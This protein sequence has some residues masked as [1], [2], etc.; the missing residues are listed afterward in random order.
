MTQKLLSILLVVLTLVG[1]VVAQAPTPP[2][3]F[4]VPVA[5]TGVNPSGGWN[6][7]SI[8]SVGALV[9]SG[10]TGNTD[11]NPPQGF[12]VPFAPVGVDP[13][14]NWAFMKVDNT[15]AIII[16]GALP[17]PYGANGTCLVSTGP[18]TQPV[19]GSC[20]GTSSTNWSAI[21][22][23]T[24]TIGAG[25]FNVG[26]GSTLTVI[27]SGVINAN[28]IA[29]TTVAASSL[30]DQFLRTT[31]S[32]VASWVA[33]PGCPNDGTHALVYDTTAHAPACEVITAGTGNV[34]TAVTLTANALVLGNGGVDTKVLASLGTTTTVLH[35]NAAGVPSFGQVVA[36]DTDTSIAHTGVDI[37]T[38]YQVTATH[39]AAALP[40]NQGGTGTISTLTGLVR[41]S[42]SA[43]SAAE[44]SGDATTS[45]SNVVTV[46]KINGTTVP[47]NLAAHQV[48][49]TTGV[50][51]GTWKT[52][53]DCG[54]A[55]TYSQ[56]GDSFGCNPITT[57]L[58]AI[59][60]A[61]GANS[62]NNGDN[63]Q[64]WNW[65]LTTSS[66]IGWTIGENVAS[67]ATGTPILF[68]V[69]TLA[70]S[71]ARPLQVTAR[72][73][74]NG[75]FVDTAGLLQKL[76]TGGVAT[77]ALASVQGTGTLVQLSTS[78]PT[79][80]TMVKFDANGNTVNSLLTDDG[81]TLK[82]AGTGGI[83]AT[84]VS[85]AGLITLGAGSGSNTVTIAA[86][87]G[88][89]TASYSETLPAAVAAGAWFQDAS[90]N[91]SFGTLGVPN[92]GT[93]ATTFTSNG[94]LYGN[95]TSAVGVTAAGGAGTLCLVETN[96][97]TPTFGSCSG[98]S[99]T[100]WSAL[101]NPTGNLTLSMGN[102]TTTFTAGTATTN[103]FTF[104]DTTGNAGTGPLV[105]INTVGTSAALPLQV[106]AQGTANGVQMTTAGL[107]QPIGTGG[108]KATQMTWNGL[109]NPTGN[110]TLS[111]GN[112]TTTFTA[113]TATTTPFLFQDTTGNTGVGALV[114]ISTV[115]TSTA[116]P[117]KITA[118]GTSNGVQMS[119]AGVLSAIGT[120]GI[121][122]T[123][124]PWSGL[125][126]PTTNLS[127]S[128]GTNI[129]T[130]T[131]GTQAA[132]ST[133][134]FTLT[135]AAD[136]GVSTT[137][138][139]SFIDT[140]GNTRTGAL[141][142]VHTV[143]T[144]TA[145]P[146]K[147]TAQGTA[148]GIEMST[149]G[150]VL[151]LGTGGVDASAILNT[152]GV[153]HG[154]TGA[155]TFTTN[156][157][158]F[159]NGTNAINVTAAGGAGTLCLQETNGG[160][161]VFGSCSGAAGT[162]WSS[163]TAPSGNLTLAMATNTTQFN[164]STAASPATTDF[165]FKAPADSG[166]STVSIFMFDDTTANTRTGPLLDAH[167]VGTS[168]ALP[169][170]FTAQGTSNGVSM[171]T[172]GL[173]QHIGTGGIEATTTTL[174]ISTSS[175]LT[176]GALFNT[177]LTIG[178]A[179][180]VTSAASLTSNALVLGAGSQGSKVVAGITSDGTSV[181]NLGVAGASVGG[182]VLANAT[183]GTI[184]IQ[185]VTGA[186]GAVVLSAPART[187][188][189]ATTT[190]TLTSGDAASFDAS[191]NLID[192][193]VVAANITTQTGNGAANQV[194]T[195]TS[196]NK[197]CVPGTVTGAMMTSGTVT[198]TQLAAQYSKGACTIGWGGTGSANA[199]SSGDDAIANNGCYNDS[200]VTR[201]ITAVKC[202][203]D[204]ASNTTTVN[205]TMGAD[206][207]GTSILS[208]ALTCGNSYNYSATGT[209]SG[210]SW[211]TGTGIRPVMGGTLTGT[212]ISMIVEYTY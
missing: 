12:V 105:Q 34:T 129:S 119:A 69:Q 113:G 111:V 132:P 123:A 134:D 165:E 52:I 98:S 203:S 41:G 22:P 19:W 70:T 152:L 95:G 63:A 175:P 168:T 115:G 128:M 171:N 86:P 195:Y 80:N 66:K 121:T 8:S 151:P 15:G 1:G 57:A 210:T 67:N 25:T 130:F 166:T 188:T 74:A 44:L 71:T 209:L 117:V 59:T 10:A 164:W 211:T 99:S 18:G 147:I 135:A 173:L 174:T 32:G 73:I 100:I 61:G 13:N 163:L 94:I 43:M 212:S 42:A 139:F 199:L 27:G 196:T 65:S 204:N 53:N 77:A 48:L 24:G 202:R 55:L 206:G 75:I 154:G 40:I 179:T 68:D 143:G 159:G 110:L 156:G 205:P 176:G 79:S 114:Q 116:L 137:S 146:F 107:L 148:N 108:I 96:G 172:A 4:V 207:T 50:A 102:N 118:Q 192:S 9:V 54:T 56:A 191:G 91:I 47:T 181:L 45:G 150:A 167:T 155:T 3:G 112:N 11:P 184:T 133:S 194:C 109:Q 2:T 92:G 125:T 189:L 127:L 185:P 141:F 140:T 93:G 16:A 182:I 21:V 51:T 103:P 200:G 64:V 58:S 38:S 104:N 177:N 153:V 131:W 197:V 178:C 124:V 187:A 162:A 90:G 193:T 201:T 84:N 60:A 208:G 78:T 39:L 170:R 88:A 149:S 85:G 28:Q 142:D 169:V 23:G 122:A 136:S 31:A 160:A 157:I 49:V 35:G 37:N 81:T 97:G 183:S 7:A 158:L 101:T 186:L 46:A 180:C 14:G 76:G 89:I 120:G 5:M 161:P 82:Y 145:L 198:A 87:A 36:A 20:S 72:G 30:A 26:T 83:Q 106:T 17:Q 144:S 190:G 126:N 62:I 6:H 33:M 29:A 138:I